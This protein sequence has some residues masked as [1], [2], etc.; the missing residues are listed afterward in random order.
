[1]TACIGHDNIVA[2]FELVGH[3]RPAQ[4]TICDSVQQENGRLVVVACAMIMNGNAIGLHISFRPLSHVVLLPG[5]ADLKGSGEADVSRRGAHVHLVVAARYLPA[6]HRDVPIGQ[7]MRCGVR[8]Q[9][10]AHIPGLARLQLDLRPAHQP[11]GRFTRACRQ[12]EIDLGDLGT[13]T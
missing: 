5:M 7:W 2:F 1:M 4:A 9:R 13:C 11:P 12:A 6:V 3:T 8:V 10:H